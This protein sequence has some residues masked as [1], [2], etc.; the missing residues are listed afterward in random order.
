MRYSTCCDLDI[1][2]DDTARLGSF[3]YSASG[4]KNP[5][6]RV[7]ATTT[8]EGEPAENSLFFGDKK[9][10]GREEEQYRRRG[11]ITWYNDCYSY[12]MTVT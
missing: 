6:W 4:W 12:F 10:K 2:R 3:S 11:N 5:A 1:S 8:G 9:R 7:N